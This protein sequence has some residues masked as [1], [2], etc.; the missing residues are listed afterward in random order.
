MMP[1]KIL[2]FED[3]VHTRCTFELKDLMSE[4]GQFTRLVQNYR[5]RSPP[6]LGPCFSL[7]KS[8]SLPWQGA[9]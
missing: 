7:V 4:L 8:F 2:Y 1:F 9:T 5:R 3:F 6:C